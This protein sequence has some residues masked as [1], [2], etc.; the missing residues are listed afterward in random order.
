MVTSP[1]T[2][3]DVTRRTFAKGTAATAAAAGLFGTS[4]WLARDS[5]E[6]TGE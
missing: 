6:A 2:L 1:N 4:T 5:T 3:P